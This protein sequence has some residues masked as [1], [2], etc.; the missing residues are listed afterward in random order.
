MNDTLH[1]SPIHP[2]DIEDH[3]VLQI[4]RPDELRELALADRLSLRI[5]IWLLQRAH[6]PRPE[7][8]RHVS[9]D[10]DPWLRQERAR[11]ASEAKAILAYDLQ[12]GLR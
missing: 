9:P 10:S 11:S 7:R 4:P 8:R 5:G 6:R 2:P 12:R 1:R 3:P